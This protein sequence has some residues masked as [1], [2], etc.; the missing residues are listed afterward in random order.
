[1]RKVSKFSAAAALAAG[2]VFALTA[3]ASANLVTNGDFEADTP[4]NQTAPLGWT[5]TPAS[6]GSDFFVGPGP[7]FGAFAGVNSANFGATGNFDDVLSQ[8]LATTP[9]H[10]YTISF[11]L[12]LASTDS[13]NDFSVFFGGNQLY[14]LTNGSSFGYQLLSFTSTATSASTTL[15]FN[16]REVPSWYDLDNVDVEPTVVPEPFTL[17]LFGTGLAGAVAMRRRKKAK[18]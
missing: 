4:A 12:A 2:A 18:A 10:S 6:S 16:G 1:M 9:G 5:L 15:S 14:T 13:Q 7:G 3:P 17:S 8:I 11:E